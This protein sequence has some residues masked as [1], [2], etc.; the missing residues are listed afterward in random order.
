[1]KRENLR[2]LLTTLALALSAP[3]PSFAQDAEKKS[4]EQRI[5]ELEAQVTEL[6]AEHEKAEPAATGS[7]AEDQE[8]ARAAAEEVRGMTP[9]QRK[10]WHQGLAAS[11]PANYNAA[12]HLGTPKRYVDDK[13]WWGLK[14]T[15]TELRLSGWVQFALFHDFQGN[16]LATKQEFSSG[17][18]IV[19]TLKRP[20]TGVDVGSSRIFLEFRHLFDWKQKR[21][22]F[23]GVT[24]VLFEMDLGGDLLVDGLG[25]RVRQF[26]AQIGHLTF[27]QADSA[28]T[29]GGTWPADFDNGAPGAY[30]D[31]RTPVLRYAAALSKRQK[32]HA[33]VL[34]TGIEFQRTDFTN[35]TSA[36]NAPDMVLRYD[37]SPDWGNLMAAVIVRYFIAE[38]TLIDAR[39]SK[40]VAGGT[41][42]GWA[43]IPTKNEDRLKWNFLIGPGVSGLMYDTSV[44][45]GLDGTYVDAT[46]TLLTTNAWGIWAG[47]ERPWAEKWNS[48]FM[49][50]YVD[51]LN[52]AGQAP[53]TFSNSVTATV[54][55]DYEP[56]NHL[57]IAVE[58]FYGRRVNFDAQFGQD[59]R[60][61]L[62]FR[63]MM[64]R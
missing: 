51:V 59:H 61:N 34:T 37:Y 47:W 45:G 11:Q 36:F 19:P 22:N 7:D 49:L 32:K 15:P 25:P 18:V 14:G 52:V 23:P 43:T 3:T 8:A 55:L 38:S 28:F 58:Y 44:A 54:T 57:F 16:A 33:H 50:S 24:H 35:A 6:Q 39:A 63:Y 30:P 21:K 64:N 56:V 13:G 2:A 1:M 31:V 42:S 29:N 12:W 53:D 60:L 26:F 46:N 41:L 10:R 9:E 40:W 5:Q 20:S 17:A 62:V 4:Q 27:G 48:L